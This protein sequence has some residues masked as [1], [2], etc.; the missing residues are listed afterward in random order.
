MGRKDEGRR[1]K[2]EGRSLGEQ[3]TLNLDRIYRVYR[4]EDVRGAARPF[5]GEQIELPVP[6][7]LIL[8]ILS[9]PPQHRTCRSV[10]LH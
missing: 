1:A 2:V 10:R 6:I 8:L 7:L 3:G 5:T 9:N 4:I